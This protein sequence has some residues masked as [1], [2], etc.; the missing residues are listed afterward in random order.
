MRQ[1]EPSSCKD[2]REIRRVVVEALRNFAIRR[3]HFQRH[4]GIGHNGVVTNRGILNINRLI[5]LFDVNWLPLPCTGRA[6]FQ[7]PVIG[8][9]QIEV[10][11]IPFRWIGSPSAFQAARDRIATDGTRAVI[12]PAKALLL[13]LSTFWRLAQVCST[14]ITMAFTHG[15]TTSR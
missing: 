14:A 3:I 1:L 5:F 13:Q 6:L 11:V 12:H 10:A 9:E 4:I 15:V 7:L 2:I 8:E